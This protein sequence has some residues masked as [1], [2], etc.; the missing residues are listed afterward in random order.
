MFGIQT[1][2]AL[3]VFFIM[4]F[5]WSFTTR[6]PSGPW[7]GRYTTDQCKP[8]SSIHTSID[9]SGYPCCLISPGKCKSN[10][11]PQDLTERKA[12]NSLSNRFNKE[13]LQNIG[14]QCR[15][16]QDLLGRKVAL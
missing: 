9:V 13:S 12:Q 10:G 16:K 14:R 15:R 5:G 7:K 3:L 1:S 8:D 11:F 2:M 4:L 6:H